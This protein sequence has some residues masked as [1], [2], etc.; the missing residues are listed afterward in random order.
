MQ[1]FLLIHLILV[2]FILPLLKSYKA[3]LYPGLS[4]AYGGVPVGPL[5]S[6]EKYRCYVLQVIVLSSGLSSGFAKVS[7]IPNLPT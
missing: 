4:L 1:G 2:D 7:V 5:L 3:I 6:R